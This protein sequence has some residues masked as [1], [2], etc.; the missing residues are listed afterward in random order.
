[1]VCSLLVLFVDISDIDKEFETFG[2]VHE[3]FYEVNEAPLV[4]LIGPHVPHATG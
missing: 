1:M 4:Q 2:G 3:G